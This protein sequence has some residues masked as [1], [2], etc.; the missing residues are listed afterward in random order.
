MYRNGLWIMGIQKWQKPHF[1]L[2]P[3]CYKSSVT[4]KFLKYNGLLLIYVD[5]KN[6]VYWLLNTSGWP[7]GRSIWDWPQF[8]VDQHSFDLPKA[9]VGQKSADSFGAV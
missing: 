3:D 5:F 2:E 9:D 4:T 8:F 7:W 1:K 6:G